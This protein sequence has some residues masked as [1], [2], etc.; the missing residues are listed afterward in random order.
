MK[1]AVHAKASDARARAKVV[2]I[3][4]AWPSREGNIRPLALTPLFFVFIKEKKG[5]GWSGLNYLSLFLLHH[6]HSYHSPA[7]SFLH[8][9]THTQPQDEPYS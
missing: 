5:K 6:F 3:Y 2:K 7:H 4:K 9:H 8:S 1:R